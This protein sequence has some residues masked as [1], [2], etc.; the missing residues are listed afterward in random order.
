MADDT[1]IATAASR[2]SALVIGA[3]RGLGLALVREL[4][5]RGWSVTATVRGLHST[6]LHSLREK[7]P[8]SL[9][10]E[11]LDVTKLDEIAALRDRLRS[12]TFDLL[13]VN[14]GIANGPGETIG[15][16]TLE[17]FTR[18]MV[19]NVFG[20]MRVVEGL[21]DL[22]APRG[23]VALMSSRL[24]SVAGNETGGWEIYRGSKAALNMLMRSYAHRHR[25][26]ARTLLLIAPGWVRTD[27]GGPAAT[28]S[29]E[30]SIRGVVDTIIANRGKRGLH[31]LDYRGN[32]LPW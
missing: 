28:L 25:E 31:F 1:R 27:L 6:E 11:K 21:Q 3:S 22:V 7:H 26:D 23:T 9:E 12:Q 17:Q 13:Y 30:E 24:G 16:A 4:L 8:G 29:V 2:L 14:A 10:I 32:V 19:T 20:P 5:T 18:L 15:L